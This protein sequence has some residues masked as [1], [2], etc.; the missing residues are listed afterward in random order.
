MRQNDFKAEFSLV[1]IMLTPQYSTNLVVLKDKKFQKQIVYIFIDPF[2]IFL[3]LNIR[4]FNILYFQQLTIVILFA[5]L[6]A[7]K[8]W[9]WSFVND[10]VSF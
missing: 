8:F 4:V 3:T 7:W 1:R 9:H 6:Q 5:I 2:W 10:M